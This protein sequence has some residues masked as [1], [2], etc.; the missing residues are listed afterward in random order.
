M[1]CI[2]IRLI[3]QVFHLSKCTPGA[4]F[5]A[6]GIR[7]L[8]PRSGFLAPSRNFPLRAP[9]FSLRAGIF[10]L[11]AAISCSE[12]Q[13]SRSEPEFSRSELQFSRSEPGFSRLS[14][15][16]LA[17][18]RKI[19]ALSEELAAT[20][21]KNPTRSSIPAVTLFSVGVGIAVFGAF[22]TSGEAHFQFFVRGASILF[23]FC[24]SRRDGKKTGN[25][26]QLFLLIYP[27]R[28]CANSTAQTL[29]GFETLLGL[30][31]IGMPRFYLPPT[32]STRGGGRSVEAQLLVIPRYNSKRTARKD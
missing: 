15:D 32:P 16:F 17:P 5:P 25:L 29:T 18:S 20:G 26:R 9:I 21:R 30:L 2:S 31:A 10:S 22:F 27:L 24:K 12:L 7:F 1:I 14:E 19:G 4:G 8:A 6:P 23:N 3:C 28:G 13:F 11:R